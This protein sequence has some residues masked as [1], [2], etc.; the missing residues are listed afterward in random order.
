MSRGEG[1]DAKELTAHKDRVM[2]VYYKEGRLA[3]GS[4]DL[5]IRWVGS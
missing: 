4:D 2:V 5:S 3:T 1:F